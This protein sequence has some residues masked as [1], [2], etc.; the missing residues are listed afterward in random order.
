MTRTWKEIWEARPLDATRPSL[1]ARLD[2]TQSR[3][4]IARH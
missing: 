4:E 2:S 1:L 3:A